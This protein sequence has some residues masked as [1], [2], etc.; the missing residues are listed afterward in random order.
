MTL[1]RHVRASEAVKESLEAY[2]TPIP[3]EYQGR[4]EILIAA[5]IASRDM[6]R[7]LARNSGV[8][9]RGIPERLIIGGWFPR[10]SPAAG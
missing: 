3:F 9:A 1:W 5:A 7:R 6:I 4:K 8:G 10:P 2:S